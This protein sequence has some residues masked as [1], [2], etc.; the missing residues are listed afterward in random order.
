MAGKASDVIVVGGGVAGLTAA[1]ALARRGLTV[2]LLEARD[3]VGGRIFTARPRGWKAPV[4]LGA[5]FIHDGNQELWNFL[6]RGGVKI[7]TVPKDHWYFGNARLE[8]I[9]D[10]ARQIERVTE[11]IQPRKMLG[12]SFRDFLRRSARTFDP[13]DQALATEFVEGFQGA[14]TDDMSAAAVH[15]ETLDPAA[16]FTVPA[17]YDQLVA[18]LRDGLRKPRAR[19]LLRSPV[20]SITWKHGAVV[21]Q[22]LRRKFRARAAIVALPLGVL[23]A[24]PPR[25]GAVRFDPPLRAKAA[26]IAKMEVGHVIRITLRFDPR[27]WAVIVPRKLQ[28]AAK[29]FGFIHSRVDGVPTWWSLSAN[30]VLTGWAGGPAALQLMH[31]SSRGICETALASLSRIFGTPKHVLR[32]SLVDFATHNWTRDPFSRGAYSFIAAGR[33]EAAEKIRGPVEDTLFFAGEATADDE[34]TGTVH[35]AFSSGLR[36]AEEAR[37]ALARPTASRGK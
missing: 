33:D 6:R 3:R 1:A 16:Q 12:W 30:R 10:L 31:R 17:G 37:K 7:R 15:G 22:A 32:R 29:G 23:Q 25:R 19:L 35:G 11:K 9:H 18:R 4:E 27:Q 21:V 24:R 26:L 20:R 13:R 28:R 34:E 8:R 5:E 2:T 36:A 14:P